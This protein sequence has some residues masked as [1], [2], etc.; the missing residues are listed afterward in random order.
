MVSTISLGIHSSASGNNE[1]NRRATSPKITTPGPDCHTIFRTGGVL[2]SA[3][4][5][6]CQLLKKLCCSA[7]HES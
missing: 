2:R 1:A 4:R 5:R 3:V 6:S 7:M